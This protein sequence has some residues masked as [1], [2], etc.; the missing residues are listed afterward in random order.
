[1]SFEIEGQLLVDFV[2]APE[3]EFLLNSTSERIWSTDQI[4]PKASMMIINNIVA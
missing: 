4:L 2:V 1:M 3:Y